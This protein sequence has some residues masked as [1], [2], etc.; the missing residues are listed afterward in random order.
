MFLE[1]D[2]V[3]VD[4]VIMA[5]ARARDPKTIAALRVLFNGMVLNCHALS[6]PD[7]WDVV[8]VRELQELGIVNSITLSERH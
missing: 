4:P 1:I 3:A 7:H 8:K 6:C 5:E 2:E